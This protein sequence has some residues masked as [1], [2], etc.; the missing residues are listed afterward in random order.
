MPKTRTR[1]RSHRGGRPVDPPSALSIEA[2][3][4]RQ[5]WRRTRHMVESLLLVMEKGIS[6]ADADTD[7][8]WKRLFGTKDSAVVTLQKL[9]QLLAELPGEAGREKAEEVAPVPLE[10]DEMR[11]ITQWL[12]ETSESRGDREEES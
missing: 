10:P 6:S 1:A 12:K 8:Q 4:A 5:V 11:L 3:E 2:Q 7:E 9:V